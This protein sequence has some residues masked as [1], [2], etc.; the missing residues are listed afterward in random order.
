ME[1]IAIVGLSCLLPGAKNPEEFW[2]NLMS[3][4]NSTSRIT[5]E[6]IGVDPAIFYDPIKGNPDKYYS[7]QG[8]YIRDFDFQASEYN[9][10]QEFLES[11]DNTFQWSLYTAQQA[12]K[13]SG[14]FNDKSVLAKCGVILGNLSSPTRSTYQLFQP[15][16]QEVMET[17]VGKLL[18]LEDFSLA[19]ASN[20]S[21]KSPYNAMIS[22]FPAALVAKAFSL[23]HINFCL[24]AAC[25]SSFYAIKLASHYLWSGKADMMLAGAISCAEPLA[26]RMGFASLYASSDNEITQPFDKNSRGIISSEGVGMVV[27]KRYSD[28][29]RDG[30][31]ILATICGNGL[32]NDGKGKHLLSPNP[33]GQML[34]FERAYQEANINPQD[35]SYVECHATGTPIGDPIE[36]GSIEKFFGK[37]QAKPLLGGAKANVGHLL[38]AAGMVSLTKIILSMR[39]GVIPPTINIQEPLTSENGGISGEQ[40]VQTT[41]PWPKNSSVKHAGI[42]AFG[43]GGSNSHLILE[44][45]ETTEIS[46]SFDRNQR[47]P[48]APAKIAIVGMDVLFGNCDGLDAF[49]KTIYEGT[50]HFIAP[51]PQRWCG[52]TEKSESELLEKHDFIKDALSAKGAY[53]KDFPIDTIACKIPPNEV[54]D[55][56]RQNTLI[57][58]IANRAIQ[59]AGIEAGGNIAVIIGAETELPLHGIY[60]RWNLSW[61]LREGSLAQDISLPAEQIAELETVLKDSIAKPS[62]G[63]RTMS[64]NSNIMANRISA[65]WDFS[66]PSFSV[67]AGENS[68]LKALEAAQMLLT[69]GEV[70][71][72]VLGA[73]DLAASWEHVW[74]QTQ[75]AKINTGVNNT[76]SYDVSCNGWSIGEGAGV[77]ILKR[78]DVARKNGD[79]IYAAIEGI[80]FARQ[81]AT[82]KDLQDNL[83]TPDAQTINQACQQAFQVA[84]IESS[85][86][87]YLEVFGSGIQ[88]QDKAEINGLLAAYESRENSLNCGIGSVKANIGHTFIASGIASLIK[89]ALCLYHKYIPATPNWSGVKQPELWQNSPFYVAPESKPWLKSKPD[90]PRKAAINSMGIDGASAHVILSESSVSSQSG[91]NYLAQKSFYLFPLAANSLD[92]LRVQLESL[93]ESIVSTSSL[94]KSALENFTTFKKNQSAKYVLSILGHNQQEIAKEIQ[95]AR[96]GID[97]AFTKGQDWQTPLGSYFAPKP[98]SQEGEIAFVYPASGSSYTGIGRDL[99]RLFPEFYD[100]LDSQDVSTTYLDLDLLLYPRSLNKLSTKELQEL[101]EQFIKKSKIMFEAEIS[102]ASKYTTI[103]QHIFQLQ[104]KI[105]FGNSL[106]EVSMLFAQDVWRVNPQKNNN[107]N[108]SSVFSDRLS[109]SKKAVRQYWGL[110]DTSE[111]ANLWISYVLMVTPEQVRECLK[112]QDRVYLTQINTPEEVLI[113]GDPQACKKVI[114][115]LGC[116]AFPTPF[117]HVVHCEVA[118]SEYDELVK[119]NTFDI[120]NK[121][122]IAF[123]SASE[124][125]PLTLEANML[126]HSMARVSSQQIDFPRIV[127]RVYDD[128]AKIFIELG[129]GSNCSRWID[130]ILGDREHITLSLNRKGIDDHTSIVKALAKLVSHGVTLDLSPL[131]PRTDAT[132]T[133]RRSLNKTITLGGRSIEEK[134]LTE[135]NRQLFQNIATQI[136]RQSQPIVS[137]SDRS[138]VLTEQNVIEPNLYDRLEYHKLIENSSKVLEAHKSLLDARQESSKKMSE[139]IQLKIDYIQNIL[140]K[141]D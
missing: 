15:L 60:Q 136:S 14:Y 31:R 72:V 3:A 30:D 29:V 45:N 61:Q 58:K 96:Q 108:S 8:G 62:N 105:A 134:L 131:Y 102:L 135:A 101:E 17:I 78:E 51:P 82:P 126:T 109:G 49:E 48:V 28:A 76:L 55:L 90:L 6:D 68:A 40:I 117:D 50:Q 100:Y 140:D 89:T 10:P 56:N 59:D 64:Y 11:L 13:D 93:E 110:P 107:S 99:F 7:L 4:R 53:I 124:Y 122:N 139:I 111:N 98:L 103:L 35:I 23:S 87:E 22:G 37:H 119:I 115:T 83:L 57:L 27:L 141:E 5:I 106:G 80:G 121:P 63:N 12:L 2:Q 84:G 32:S 97:R 54:E 118:Q 81:D 137:T 20:K 94:S 16:Y 73:I 69:T 112:N 41:T 71:A 125:Q 44:L 18:K 129:A 9:L 104:P 43:F 1:K 138:E 52:I 128:G 34:A 113:A 26:M 19:S 132:S 91:R 75:L 38:T 92:E 123:Y 25:S 88:Q 79:R 46:N 120:Y 95:F 21:Q 66:G 67:S 77:V 70:D 47:E 85:D 36:L 42:N 74:L 24:D 65:L 116:T 130:K 133:S 86:I 39:H 33:K 114:E 127:N